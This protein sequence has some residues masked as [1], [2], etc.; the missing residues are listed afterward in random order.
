M[1]AMTYPATHASKAREVAEI[2]RKNSLGV[3]EWVVLALAKQIELIPDWSIRFLASFTGLPI[4]SSRE[5]ALFRRHK[6]SM[7]A[8]S[9]VRIY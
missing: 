8:L 7:R 6:A 5:T 4:L 2:L 9:T 1:E 3:K